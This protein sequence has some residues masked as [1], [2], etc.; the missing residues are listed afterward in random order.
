MVHTKPYGASVQ[1]IVYGRLGRAP[2][3]KV[4]VRVG[5]DNSFKFK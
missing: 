1:R 3:I 5:L 2:V 4:R